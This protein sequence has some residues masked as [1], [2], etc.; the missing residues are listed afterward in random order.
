MTQFDTVKRQVLNHP[1]NNYVTFVEDPHSYLRHWD[2]RPAETYQGITSLIGEYAPFDRMGIA[3][4]YANKHNM[5]VKE[6][7]KEWNQST[8]I[9]HTIHKELEE[10]GLTGKTSEMME[11][12]NVYNFLKTNN[13]RPIAFEWVVCDDNI[14]KATAI[15]LVTYH[16]PTNRIVLMDYKTSKR[17][18]YKPFKNKRGKPKMM[19]YPL[20]HLPSVNFYKY[21]LQLCIEIKWLKEL[22][23]KNNSDMKIAP[24]GYILH[25]KGDHFKAHRTINLEFDIDRLY[26]WELN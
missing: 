3:Y 24:Y 15:D 22:Y 4:G 12:Y 19:E 13:F 1:R 8:V 6:V 2:D 26:Q 18:D 7:L 9:G 10:V 16:V 25:I 17:I 20:T 21:S 5:T 11:V 23:F 14:K